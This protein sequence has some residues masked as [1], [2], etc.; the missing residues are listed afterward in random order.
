[1]SGAADPIRPAGPTSARQPPLARVWD[2]VVRLFH[3]SLVGGFALAWFTPTR[4]ESVHMWAG[5]AAAGLIGLRLVWGII[6]TRHARFADFVKR[7]AVVL[8]YLGAILRGTEAR[9]L[10]HNPAG[11]AMILALMAAMLGTAY[12]GWLMYTDT[13][14]GDDRMVAIHSAFAHGLLALV[15]LHLAGVA[16]ASIRHRENLPRAMLTGQKRP[17]GPGDVD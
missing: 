11:G 4:S 6:G 1:M 10:G 12:T 2:P 8:A 9:Y 3:W 16:L 5:Y 7:P 15:V 14:Y 13:W 17:A